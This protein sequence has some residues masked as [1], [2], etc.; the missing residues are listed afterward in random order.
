MNVII[1]MLDHMSWGGGGQLPYKKDGG[2]Y[3][4]RG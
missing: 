3:Y 1:Q 2:A 4:I